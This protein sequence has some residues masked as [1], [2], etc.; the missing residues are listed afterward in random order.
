[1]KNLI[2]KIV[3]ALANYGSNHPCIDSPPPPPQHLQLGN[4]PTG[5]EVGKQGV[6]GLITL[7]NNAELFIN[8]KGAWGYGKLCCI[9]CKKDTHKQG[10]LGCPPPPPPPSPH[11][12][13][14]G[15]KVVF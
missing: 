2:R 7:L 4:L 5:T 3:T 14:G 12:G 11:G 6:C 10:R 1:M 9:K 13:G 15:G 8:K